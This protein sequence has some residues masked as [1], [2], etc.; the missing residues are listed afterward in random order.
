MSLRNIL[1]RGLLSGWLLAWLLVSAGV[2]AEKLRPFVLASVEAG[3]LST[4]VERVRDKLKQGGFQ[5]VGAYAP[6][7]S[8]YVLAVTT[9]ELMQ[10]A[11][12]DPNAAWLAAVRVAATRV[13]DRI[14]ISYANPDYLRYAYRIKASLSGV[15]RHLRD[16]LGAQLSFGARNMTARKLRR[17]HYAFGMEYFDDQMELV[18]YGN[19]NSA[20]RQ[21]GKHLRE[22][23]D[24][25][26]RVYQVDL[27]DVQRT[28]LGVAITQGEGSD[29]KVMAA[30]DKGR[31][32][33]TA[34]LPYEILIDGGK[35]KA[36][37]PRFRIAIDFPD[38]KMSGKTSFFQIMSSPDAIQ[39]ALTQAVGGKV[40]TEGSAEFF[41]D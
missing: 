17:Y 16:A 7:R 6:Y 2:A 28:L 3:P 36:L 14:Q 12:D 9:P 40:N 5:I 35:V 4:V 13:G 10:I 29:G 20:L 8:A 22:R 11:V 33:H 19:Y 18:D 21:V 23:S 37:H 34:H 30:I 25:V 26:S 31:Y 24:G 1:Y 27:P 15:T 38:L 39:Q 32:R 41:R